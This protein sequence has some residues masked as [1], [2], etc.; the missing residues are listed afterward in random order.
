MVNIILHGYAGKMGQAVQS[1]QQDR[2]D[3][4]IVAGIDPNVPPASFPTYA[5]CQECDVKADVIV[6][7]STATAVPALLDYAEKREIPTVLCTTGLTDEMLR[8]VE[9]CSTKV[10]LF[11]SANM[12][13]GIHI[14]AHILKQM[15]PLLYPAGF[16]IEIIESHHRL[17][18]DAP[19]GTALFLGDSINESLEKPLE[20]EMNRTAG[21][22]RQDAQIGFHSLRGGTLAG[23]HKVLFAG[24][25]ETLSLTHTAQSKGL[26]VAGAIE[27]AKFM[28]GKAPGLYTM[29]DLIDEI[30]H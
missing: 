28:K 14:M 9:K 4:N 5:S 24:K 2:G 20:F 10:G 13:L 7:F 11:R 12:S 3:F 1:M 18:I 15:A 22:K 21:G 29:S 8:Q 30:A 27:A 6:D 26:F 16:D 19:S 23:E 17:K 25:D